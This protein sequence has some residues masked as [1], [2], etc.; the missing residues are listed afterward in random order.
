[1]HKITNIILNILMSIIIIGSLYVMAKD[2]KNNK[3]YNQLLKATPTKT[4]ESVATISTNTIDAPDAIT[5]YL[6]N[7]YEIDT[8][9]TPNN[10][11]I[12]I[13]VFKKYSFNK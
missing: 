5:E 7:G 13:I 10:T 8:I 3:Y 1:M 6:I 11:T 2:Y 12:T 4:L 9:I